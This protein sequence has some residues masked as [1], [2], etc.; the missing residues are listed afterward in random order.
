MLHLTQNSFNLISALFIFVLTALISFSV[1][2]QAGPVTLSVMRF[3][4]HKQ[5]RRAFAAA[6]GGTMAEFLYAGLAVL[7][8]E[9]LF[10]YIVELEAMSYFG[11][12]VMLGFG[13]YLILTANKKFLRGY[14]ITYDRG[15]PLL[16]GFRLGLLNPQI[17]LFYCVLLLAYFQFK[18]TPEYL[19]LRYLSFSLGAAF[20]FFLLLMLIM[21]FVKRR[22][23]INNHYF[24]GTRIMYFCGILLV[25]A[26]IYQLVQHFIK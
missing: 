9:L 11:P 15:N 8:A 17:F 6:F 5:K 18:F 24:R 16:T 23:R 19:V 2:L 22:G 13:L 3:A 21:Y 25:V 7:L 12:V 10:P 14:K 4:M 20:G 26:G 1:S